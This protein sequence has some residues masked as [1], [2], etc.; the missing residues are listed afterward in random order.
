MTSKYEQIK[1]ALYDQIKAGLLLEDETDVDVYKV[2]YQNIPLFPAVAIQTERRNKVKKGINRVGEVT[3][4]FSVWVYIK[5]LDYNDAENECMR[6]AEIIE[7]IIEEDKT[8]GGTVNYLSIDD[9]L[10]FG[11]VEARDG[12]FLQGA[13]ISLTTTYR[14]EG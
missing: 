8:L 5:I 4:S 7:N 10:G 2:F 11:Q 13:K 12:I 9:E 14:K 1:K 6:L 3:L